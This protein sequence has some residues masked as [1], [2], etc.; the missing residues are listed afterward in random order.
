ME[1][2]N[3]DFLKSK[4]HVSKETYFI[5]RR[6]AKGRKLKTGET[7]VEQGRKSRKVAFLVSGLMRAFN[8]LETGK[9]IT[10]NIFTPISFVGAFSSIVKDEPS[11][12]CYEALTEAVIFELDLHDFKAIAEKNI[13]VSNLY[14]RILEQIFIIYEKKLIEDMTLNATE[15]Y[16]RLKDK[17][18]MIDDLIPQYQIASYLNISP[19]Q[20]SRIRKS[21]L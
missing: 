21:L 14:N 17:I 2:P 11:K 19:V 8:T 9:E 10:K 16:T 13:D 20:L 5:L 3:Y 1:D 7:L 18:P 15:R 6:M 12:F 4:F